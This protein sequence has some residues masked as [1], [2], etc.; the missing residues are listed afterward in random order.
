ME[1][2]DSVR[3]CTLHSYCFELLA[4]ASVLELTGRVPR[5]LLS[6]EERFLLQ[7]LCDGQLG[8]VRMCDERLKAF[9]AAWA[10]L[11]NEE[12]GWCSDP[13]DKAFDHKLKNWLRFH[14]AMLIGELIPEIVTVSARQPALRGKD[15]SLT[16]CWWT[17]TKT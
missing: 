4:K 9:N 12:P 7:D 6:F 10:R 13:A 17:S 5:P 14:Q 11:Q 2:V 15:K 1:G 3:A 16:M 8:G